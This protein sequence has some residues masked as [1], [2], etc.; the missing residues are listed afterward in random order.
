MKERKIKTDKPRKKALKSSNI[1]TA[2]MELSKTNKPFHRSRFSELG[3]GNYSESLVKHFF[4]QKD[5]KI[6]CWKFSK[7][8]VEARG[9]KNLTDLSNNEG[10]FRTD[11]LYL[12]RTKNGKQKA[13]IKPR[14]VIEKDLKISQ[15]LF[16]LTYTI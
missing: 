7:K 15:N 8:K 9:Y 6:G 14:K 12:L 3:I 1:K 13:K 16:N 10:F 11:L 2:L 4:L 5:V